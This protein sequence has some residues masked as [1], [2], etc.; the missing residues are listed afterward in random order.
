[1]FDS[2]GLKMLLCVCC[3]LVCGLYTCVILC[4]GGCFVVT[5][6]HLFIMCVFYVVLPVLLYVC[7]VC[8]GCVYH[9]LFVAVAVRCACLMLKCGVFVFVLFAARVMFLYAFFV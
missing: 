3:I 8:C 6:A 5:V 9:D 1:M 2:I 7:V 4:C